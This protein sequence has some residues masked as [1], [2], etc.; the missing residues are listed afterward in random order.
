VVGAIAGGAIGNSTAQTQ[1]QCQQQ[2]QGSYD[3]NYGQPQN[4]A[5]DQYSQDQG[6][7]S[8]GSLAGGPDQDDGYNGGK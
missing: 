8:D 3:P 4:P 5:P 6:K 7:P 2:P 1:P